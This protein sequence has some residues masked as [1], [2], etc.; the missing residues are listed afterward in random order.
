[1]KRLLFAIAVFAF[2]VG[3]ILQ[4]ATA[5]PFL[6][7]HHFRAPVECEPGFKLVEE[8]VIENVERVVCK[9]VPEFKKKWVYSWV[10]DPFCIPDSKHGQCPN[11]SG[12]YCRKQL[13]KREVLEP[14][15]N[16]KCVTET[17]VEQV[18]VKVYRKVPC[19]SLPPATIQPGTPAPKIEVIPV[20]PLPA[21]PVKRSG[22]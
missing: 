5:N 3:L 13:V 21:T 22:L 14:C 16:M 15:P 20:R 8:T 19:D 18:A 17:I 9:M 11:C 12:P 10:A 1:M 7:G 6:K 2:G 4:P